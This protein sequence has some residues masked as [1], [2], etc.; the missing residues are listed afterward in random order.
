MAKN[1]RELVLRSNSL[2]ESDDQE[3]EILKRLANAL[4]K[5]LN[6][7]K[8]DRS[9]ALNDQISGVLARA[10]K[11]NRGLKYPGLNHNHIGDVGVRALADTIQYNP[12]L[13]VLNL[14]MNDIS[15]QGANDPVFAEWVDRAGSWLESD[16][17]RWCQCIGQKSN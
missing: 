1:L 9:E 16:W 14:V 4:E 12:T 13:Q 3:S 11:K 2:G 10:L 5:H 15:A 6:I 7:E 8:L 17:R